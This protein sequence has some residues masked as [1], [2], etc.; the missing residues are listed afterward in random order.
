MHTH[1]PGFFEMS[2]DMLCIMGSDGYFKYVNP[3]LGSRWREDSTFISIPI[4]RR[5][6]AIRIE[7][8]SKGPSRRHGKPSKD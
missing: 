6:E 3:A 7:I 2:I 4:E 8:I 5:F 1:P